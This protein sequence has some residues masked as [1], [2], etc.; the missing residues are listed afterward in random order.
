[1]QEKTP[2]PKGAVLPKGIIL[3]LRLVHAFLPKKLSVT[4][5]P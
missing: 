3:Q 1:M 2:A 5:M 4:L